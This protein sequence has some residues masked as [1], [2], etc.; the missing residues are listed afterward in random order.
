MR[1]QAG[2]AVA[3]LIPFLIAGRCAD[4]QEAKFITEYRLDRETITVPFEYLQ[5]QILVKAQINDHKNMT[6]IFDSGATSLTLDKGIGIT[7]THLADT[8][9]RE[10]EGVTKAEAIAIND[11]SLGEVGSQTHVHNVSA[12]LTDLSQMSRALDRH[13]DGI[14]GVNTMAGFVFEIDYTKKTIKFFNERTHTIALNKPDN[15]HTFLFDLSPVNPKAPL[16]VMM[17]TGRLHAGYDYDFLLDT[18]FGGFASVAHT[19]AEESGLLRPETPRIAGMA[20]SLTRHYQT[21]KI[22]ADYLW[23]GPLDLTGRTVQIDYRNGDAYGQ[24]GILGNRLWQNFKMT[25]DLQRRKLWLERATPRDKEEPDDS[26]KPSL[27]IAIRANGFSFLVDSVKRNSPAYRAGVRAGDAIV[28]INGKGTEMMNAA[29]VA[30]LL[31][32]PTGDVILALHRGVDPNLGTSGEPLT[33][34]LKPTSPLEWGGN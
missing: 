1:Q 31:T 13:I 11:L 22:H 18:G 26:D 6:L 14:M 3:L 30:N 20:F 27:G 19:A 23:L 16:S 8:Q 5:H 15:A 12:L 4:A 29:Q 28:S 33:L 9:F 34:T 24:F 25:L 32:L 7:G 17:L 10:A 2:G 21:S